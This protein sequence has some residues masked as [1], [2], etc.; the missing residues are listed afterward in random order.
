MPGDK[1][2][3]PREVYDVPRRCQCGAEWLGKSFVA[4]ALGETMPRTGMCDRCLAVEEARTKALSRRVRETV[5]PE[6]DLQPPTETRG[7]A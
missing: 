5:I 3:W 1:L 2:F 4:L 7:S 6:V